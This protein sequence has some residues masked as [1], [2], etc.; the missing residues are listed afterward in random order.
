MSRV[1][2]CG[3]PVKGR[4]DVESAASTGRWNRRAKST[5]AVRGAGGQSCD[6]PGMRCS[7][8]VLPAS[9]GG[10]AMREIFER[11]INHCLESPFSAVMR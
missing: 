5:S 8:W 1:Q 3:E 4:G 7:F 11:C 2:F 9:T 6:H 10:F